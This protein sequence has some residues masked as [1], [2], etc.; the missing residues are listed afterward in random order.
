MRKIA[1]DLIGSM[2]PNFWTDHETYITGL[3]DSE[4]V[5]LL[6]WLWLWD[7]LGAPFPDVDAMWKRERYKANPFANVDS[8]PGKIITQVRR[9]ARADLIDEDWQEMEDT[10]LEL[11]RQDDG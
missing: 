1:A 10:I 6:S 4:L 8:V 7:I 2:G 9:G 3:S 5:I 11:A